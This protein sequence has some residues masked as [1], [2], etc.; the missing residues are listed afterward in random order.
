MSSRLL[1]LA[2]LLARP[3]IAVGGSLALALALA[4]GAWYLASEKPSGAYA[5]ALMAPL[6]EEVRASGP[7]ESA[8]S[9]DLSFQIPG[10]VAAI[11]VAV[12]QH[13]AAGQVL[14][15]L[16]GGS[17]AA[18]VESAKANLASAQAN[19]SALQAGTRPEQLAI[20]QNAVAQDQDALRDAVRSA[21]VAADTALHADIDPLFT[22]PRTPN[23]QFSL[24]VPDS[25]L[26]NEINRER[27][28]LEPLLTDWGA[29]VSSAD[30]ATAEPAALGQSSSADLASLTSFADDVARAL[31]ET[32]PSA[33]LSAGAL[34]SYQN[35]VAAART[36]LS[37][38]AS[39]LTGATAALIAAEGALALG[40]AGATPQ[41]IAQGEA[42]VGAAQAALDAAT[43]AQ[44]ETALVAPIAGVVTVQNANPGETV[45]PGVPLVSIE[46]DAAFEAKVP[47][48]EADIAKI[49]PGEAVEATFDA[50]PGVVFPATVTAVDP[51]ATFSGGVASYQVT[52][53]FSQDDPRIASG[54]TAHLSILTDE[55]P[56]ALVIPASAVITES[57]GQEFVYVKGGPGPGTKTPVTTGLRGADGMVQVLSGLS[58][59]AQVLTFGSAG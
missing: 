38:A 21:Y 25:T 4:G 10:Q 57:G 28:T 2:R 55:I 45:A 29:S 43:V 5:A 48:S 15:A 31:A 13:V 22:N 41:Q 1:A 7:V 42:Q 20:E 37:G 47:V 50:Y 49:K 16:S 27:S 54:L 59:G 12:G 56:S 39:A 14:V 35:Q 51:A 34:A 24:T 3:A 52:A 11:N 30:F 23:P 18:A 17:A 46:S 58:A 44:R 26:V 40:Q 6:A 32:Q 19:L 33:A 53:T 9:T 8:Q 36:A